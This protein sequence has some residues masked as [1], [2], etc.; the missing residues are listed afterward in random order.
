VARSG[1]RPGRPV[2]AELHL[3]REYGDG[4]KRATLRGE[5]S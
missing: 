2:E 1:R 5:R 3:R 4:M